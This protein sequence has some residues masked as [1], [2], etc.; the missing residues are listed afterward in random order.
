[1]SQEPVPSMCFNTASGNSHSMAHDT[2]SPT[3]WLC[4]VSQVLTLNNHKC[5]ALSLSVAFPH[6]CRLFQL[7]PDPCLSLRVQG[8]RPGVGGS[9]TSW[10]DLGNHLVRSPPCQ[11]SGLGIGPEPP[12]LQSHQRGLQSGGAHATPGGKHIGSCQ[13]CPSSRPGDP[14]A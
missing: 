1:M 9:K 4:P 5:L 11:Q 12:P 14:T 3:C 10:R 8:H 6:F 13:A 7:P 2:V